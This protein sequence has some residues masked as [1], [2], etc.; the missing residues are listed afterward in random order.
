MN[1]TIDLPICP[2]ISLSGKS[3]KNEK[4]KHIIQALNRLGSGV[5][6]LPNDLVQKVLK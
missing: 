4:E 2:T 3:R 6:F 1:C 5:S